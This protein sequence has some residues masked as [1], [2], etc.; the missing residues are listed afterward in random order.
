MHI[1]LQVLCD[2]VEH[3][4]HTHTYAHT[5]THA[6][7]HARTHACMHTHARIVHACICT[8]MHVHTHTH[9]HTHTNTHTHTHTHTQY[10]QA[11]VHIV[12]MALVVAIC[13]HIDKTVFIS[14][15]FTVEVHSCYYTYV[16]ILYTC[17]LPHNKGQGQSETNYRTDRR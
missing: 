9:K 13:S 17:R 1:Q 5:H 8:R 4:M 11:P 7:M 16:V 10:Q 12:H 3:V 15:Y 6:H 14:E 2:S